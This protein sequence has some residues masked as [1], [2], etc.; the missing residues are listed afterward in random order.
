MK[1]FRIEIFSERA[2]ARSTFRQTNERFVSIR[3]YVHRYH[4]TDAKG[5]SLERNFE[6][7]RDRAVWTDSKPTDM[8]TRRGTRNVVLEI[9]CSRARSTFGQVDET[10]GILLF[11]LFHLLLLLHL[12]HCKRCV[13][14][15]N[16][17]CA[18]LIARQ[19]GLYS[20]RNAWAGARCWLYNRCQGRVLD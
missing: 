1:I 20:C 17:N 4:H 2:L 14:T 8:G 18:C 15:R 16:A 7:L 5:V 19:P 12:L 6:R 3:L 13:I 10:N 11:L 9:V